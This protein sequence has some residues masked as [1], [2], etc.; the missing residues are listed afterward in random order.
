ML[1]EGH[2]MFNNRVPRGE[3]AE[4]LEVKRMLGNFDPRQSPVVCELDRIFPS[5]RNSELISV[6][7]TII[8]VTGERNIDVPPDFGEL[9][10]VTRRS[11]ALIQRWVHDNWFVIEPI[12]V[13]I[14][15]T[16]ADCRI[17]GPG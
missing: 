14:R 3:G 12:I 16:D 9:T 2:M 6:A 7:R 11:R 17:I 15:L 5:C 8:R 10:R 13:D 1:E 4:A